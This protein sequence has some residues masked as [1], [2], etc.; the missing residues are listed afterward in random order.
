MVGFSS[1]GSRVGNIVALAIGGFLCVS[2]GW[3]SIF[4]IFGGAGLVWSV[5]FFALTANTPAEH[6]FIS[7]KEADYILEATRKSI[8]TREALQSKVPW[9]DILLSKACWATFFAQFTH[10]WGSYL[11]MT[12]IPSYLKEVLKFDLKSN[13]L[14]SSIPY[15]CCAVFMTIFS[16]ASDKLLAKGWLSKK[17]TRRLFLTI[18][19]IIPGFFILGLSFVTCQHVIIGVVLLSLGVGFE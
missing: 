7:K 12:Q 14:V 17:N 1:T 11:F 19:T 15:I 6:R 5:L 9:K 16:V 4:Y 2:A 8:E 18:G 10:N 3:E 13:G